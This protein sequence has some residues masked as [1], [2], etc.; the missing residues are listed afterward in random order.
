VQLSSANPSR[1]IKVSQC[2]GEKDP[3]AS[4]M[5]VARS[6]SRALEGKVLRWTDCI[7]TSL[8]DVRFFDEGKIVVVFN[9]MS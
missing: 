6:A 7:R 1:L 2:S 5:K 8:T 9:T 4:C 3:C